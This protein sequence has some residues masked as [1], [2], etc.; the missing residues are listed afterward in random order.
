MKTFRVCMKVEQDGPAERDIEIVKAVYAIDLT[1]AAEKARLL[2][3]KQNSGVNAAKIWA[4]SRE[5]IR[6]SSVAK[7]LLESTKLV[8][9]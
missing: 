3:E 6:N 8:M 9:E 7:T 2:V 4:S 1:E 5:E